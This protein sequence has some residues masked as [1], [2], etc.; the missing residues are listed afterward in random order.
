MRK[1]KIKQRDITDCG[2]ACL[3]SVSSYYGFN[4]PISKI[5]LLSGTNQK[6]TNVLGITEAANKLGFEAKGVKGNKD[7][8][9]KIPK[10]S[11][12]HIVLKNNLHHF[13]VIYKVNEKY[14][15][16]MDPAFGNITKYNIDGFCNI[17][18]GVLILLLPNEE[19]KKGDE[20]VS[21]LS[22]YIFLL[23]PH[24][25]IL[26]QVI[27]GAFIYTVLGLSTSIYVQK[28]VDNVITE[29]NQNLL[30]LLSIIMLTILIFQVFIDSI[31][32]LFTLHI[33]QRIDAHLILGYYKH[34][35]KLPQQF[36]DTMRIGE[37][38]SRLNDAVKIRLFINETMIG[39]I[40]N[41]F[42][43]ICS[44]ALMFTYYWKLAIIAI[45]IIPIYIMIF[46]IS[47]RL[48]KFT[49]RKLM[50]N[51]AELESQLIESM[52]NIYTIKTFGIAQYNNQITEN[53]FINLLKTI[54]KSGKNNIFISNISDF[55]SK[56]FTII[57]LWSGST[58]VL[59]HEL[60]PGELLSFYAL[61][62]YFS[63]PILSLI[64]SNKTVQD[65]LIA[66]D[67][68]F[69]IFDLNTES[70][71]GKITLNK[72]ETED[73]IFENVSFK[74]GNRK[75]IF[76]QLNL[77]IPKGKV[78][79]FVGESGSGKSTLIALIQ[80]LY[81]INE[82]KIRIGNYD[83]SNIDN[84]SSSRIISVVPQKI[85][86]FA[87]NIIENIAIGETQPDIKKVLE[88]SILCGVHEFVQNM[89]YGYETFLSE[90]GTNLSGGQKQKLAIAR[91]LYK[92]PEI[93]I[94]D[95]A[96]SNLD[97]KSE[98]FI[99]EL[100]TKLK[101]KGKTIII[102][103]HRLSTIKNA[104]TIFVLQNGNLVEKGTHN[105]LIN[106]HNEYFKLWEY[107]RS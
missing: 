23:K 96:T 44:I 82:G 40:V 27:F 33:G 72:N 98:S 74:Y 101:E 34:L 39:I 31:R 22:R 53:K 42:V 24:Q 19:F 51:A 86:L 25:K 49:Q 94:F 93:L 17:W 15:E 7:S 58:Y 6:G 59:K 88:I 46:L 10:P 75:N 2:A 56:L 54:Y 87:G 103:A 38:I 48:N 16:V 69:E 13:V 90:N 70:S 9:N 41:I 55:T 66:S 29:N 1:I 89:N 85:D 60:T 47:N 43:L 45:L 32:E 63:S 26:I 52:N 64:T 73:I 36:F 28:I 100:I 77:I 4:L 5:R 65:A 79:A 95:E 92:D 104:D 61:I 97:Y 57:I 102:I 3:A 78:S 83:I 81:P 91:A 30:N 35:L 37:I 18:T 21:T 106:N 8:L 84:I 76:N 12:A 107:N 71:E 20:K 99:V 80:N 11:I 62:S 68:L 105:E 67:R 50:E 14:V